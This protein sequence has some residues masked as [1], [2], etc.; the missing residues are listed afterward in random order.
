VKFK[1]PTEARAAVKVGSMVVVYVPWQMRDGS[2]PF[3][4]PYWEGKV[5]AYDAK[6]G[7][8]TIQ[9]KSVIKDEPFEPAPFHKRFVFPASCRGY[10]RIFGEGFRL[11]P[12]KAAA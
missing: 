8:Y 9:K 10:V 1:N 12:R 5:T 11:S 6:T 2:T 3:F 4:G 7:I